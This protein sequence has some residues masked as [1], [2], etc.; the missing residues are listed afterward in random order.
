MQYSNMDAALRH[1]HHHYHGF[2]LIEHALGQLQLCN[3]GLPF[4]MICK[5]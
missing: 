1:H 5:L 4:A 3:A 2:V